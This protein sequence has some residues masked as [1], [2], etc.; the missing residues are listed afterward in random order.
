MCLDVLENK[1]LIQKKKFT[2]KKGSF[3]F[4]ILVVTTRPANQMVTSTKS[5][6]PEAVVARVDTISTALAS[7][8]KVNSLHFFF[9]SNHILELSLELL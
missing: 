7:A 5:A 9:I 8:C 4:Q 2:I 6:L 1:V 3:D